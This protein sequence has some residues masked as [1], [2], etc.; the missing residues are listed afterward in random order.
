MIPGL[1]FYLTL[2]KA[3]KVSCEWL[4]HFSD[5]HD[6]KMIEEACVLQAMD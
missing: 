3:S 1:R 4:S 6:F 2:A 5:E